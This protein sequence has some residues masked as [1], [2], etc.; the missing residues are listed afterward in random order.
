MRSVDRLRAWELRRHHP[1]VGYR[2]RI[3]RAAARPAARISLAQVAQAGA[4]SG[5]RIEVLG[6][7]AVDHR[8][9]IQ[10]SVWALAAGADIEKHLATTLMPALSASRCRWRFCRA[11]GP[12][13]AAAP[14]CRA[15]SD[16]SVAGTASHPCSAGRSLP[17]TACRF[18][19]IKRRV[20]YEKPS[21]KRKRKQAAARK[22]RRKAMRR[23]ERDSE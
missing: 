18:Q 15:P 3:P 13:A 16:R 8:P 22:K 14:A 2:P 9:G 5:P 11:S 1:S 19:E 7:A 12:S 21:L 6:E 10:V 4:L 23:M 20:A 17:A